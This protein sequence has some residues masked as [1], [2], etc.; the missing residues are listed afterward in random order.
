VVPIRT[1]GNT[2][3]QEKSGPYVD[4]SARRIASEMFVPGVYEKSSIESR[5]KPDFMSPARLHLETTLEQM[6]LFMREFEAILKD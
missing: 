5:K 6:D 4:K 1:V 3:F 2:F